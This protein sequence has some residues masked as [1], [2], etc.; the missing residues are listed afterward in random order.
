MSDLTLG[1]MRQ[2]ELPMTTFKT[3]TIELKKF[4]INYES[5]ITRNIRYFLES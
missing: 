4:N 3:V 1:T 5:S 2:K